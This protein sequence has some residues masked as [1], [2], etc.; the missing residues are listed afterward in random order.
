MMTFGTFLIFKCIRTAPAFLYKPF[1]DMS[2]LS[3]G[4]YLIHIFMLGIAYSIIGTAM[5]TPM[6]ILIVATTTFL[7]SYITCKLLS[8]IPGGK[9]IIG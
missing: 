4:I 2:K 7:L 3:Y 1:E 8:F 5:F 6:N 9:Y